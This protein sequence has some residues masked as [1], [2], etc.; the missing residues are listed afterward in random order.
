VEPDNRRK[1]Q[2]GLFPFVQR[3]VLWGG[4]ELSGHSR[5]HDILI[6]GI[7]QNQ[8]GTSLGP[9]RIGEGKLEQDDVASR[10][11]GHP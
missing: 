3:D 7:K 2:S 1:Q 4:R 11:G 6:A 8:R 9:G 10:E 5:D